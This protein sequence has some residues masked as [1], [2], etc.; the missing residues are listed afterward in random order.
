MRK[1]L[2]LILSLTL[3]FS[4]SALLFSCGDEEDPN[5]QEPCTSHKDE[6][7][8][9]LC[10][11]CGEVTIVI[12]EAPSAVSVVFTA[13]DQDGAI[14]PGVTFTFTE[15]GKNDAT[16]I[17]KTCDS[18]GKMSVSLVPAV[19]RIQCDYNSDEIGYYFLDTTEIKV[20]AS[21]TALD[22]LLINNTPNGSASRPYPLYVDEENKISIP[23]GG[24]SYYIV[25]HAVNLVVSL[26]AEGVKVTYSGA[27][28]LPD[29]EGKLSFALLGVD[30]NS[31]E[32]FMIE[33]LGDQAL[34]L[35]VMVTP[36]E[37][38]LGNPYTVEALDVEIIKS[39]LTS[40]DVVYYAYVASFTG[41]L[42]L[43]VTSEDSYAAMNSNSVQVSTF[44]SGSN[45]ISLEV[46]EGD[47]VV[48][49]LAT[50]VEEDAT[51]SF[52]LSAGN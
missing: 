23:A 29:S 1:I 18:E 46:S 48:I 14:V 43:T 4:L 17:V 10:D 20:E 30:S 40:D 7:E 15:K 32:T 47:R 5:I 38:T 24:S 21:S 49:D 11:V 12:P 39:G 2:L 42:T 25:Y 31:T 3:V 8:N 16:P 19:Y 50:T 35:N 22:I 52:I 33:N 9:G 26:E 34:E 6:D 41:T 37:G 27:E 13:K 28:Y 44:A 36:K 45:V 51:V